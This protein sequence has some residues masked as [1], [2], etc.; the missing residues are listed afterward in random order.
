MN[1]I[2][3][4]LLFTVILFLGSCTKTDEPLEP[5]TEIYGLPHTR[6]RKGDYLEDKGRYKV[7]ADKDSILVELNS[8]RSANGNIV[9]HR[10]FSFY[11]FECVVDRIG[12]NAF[13]EAVNLREVTIEDGIQ[14]IGP[15]AFGR[16]GI[17]A[18]SI[19]ASIKYIDFGA[20]E[21]CK[22]LEK[23]H[24]PKGGKKIEV[25]AFSR[26]NSLVEINIPEGTYVGG[27]AFSNCSNLTT[28]TIEEGIT[29]LEGY[30]FA[31]CEKLVSIKLPS[32]LTYIPYN[33][34]QNCKNL[35]LVIIPEKIE[36]IGEGAFIGCSGLEIIEVKAE[37]P[38]FCYDNAFGGVNRE[39]CVLKV[40]KGY[41]DAYKNTQTWDSFT[42][43]VESE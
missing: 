9:I 27:N 18:L 33:F 26:C 38:P 15:F 13:L 39:L 36:E 43:I 10:K 2:S 4:L 17:T 11:D 16:S 37:K 41:K 23:V 28:V 25:R 34:L 3:A 31:N 29:G 35:P 14:S 12:E 19:P 42:K 5:E 8:F 40:P 1:R 21:E 32:G 30:A 20:F 7:I 22:N 6:P 24:L